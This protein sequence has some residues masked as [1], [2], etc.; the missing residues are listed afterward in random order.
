MAQQDACTLLDDDHKKVEQLFVQYQSAGADRSR[1][2]QLATSICNELT[3]HTQI[4]EEIFYPAVRRAVGDEQLVQEAE[5]EHQEAK[6]LIR[7]IQGS[8]QDDRL[9]MELQKAIEH[10]VGDERTKMFPKARQAKNLDLMALADQLQQRK[11]ELM[12]ASPA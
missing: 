6:Q 9:V 3:V 7:Q 8:D 4:E 11:S 10:H 1:K 2:Q 12:A 5:H